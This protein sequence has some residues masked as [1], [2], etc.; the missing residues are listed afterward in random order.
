MTLEKLADTKQSHGTDICQ[1]RIN[2]YL[3]DGRKGS[4]RIEDLY[5]AD[6]RA[7]GTKVHIQ[8]PLTH[9]F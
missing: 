5:D 9:N 1:A 6:A 8:I 7:L 2:N 3:T 4:L